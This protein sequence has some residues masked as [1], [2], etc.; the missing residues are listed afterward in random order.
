MHCVISRSP[1][2]RHHKATSVTS[3]G[4][5]P[6]SSDAEHRLKLMRPVSAAILKLKFFR[7]AQLS[8]TLAP[9]AAMSK[10]GEHWRPDF[11][12]ALGETFGDFV[13][14]PVSFEDASPHEC[15]EWFGQ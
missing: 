11:E 2:A 10:V 12:Q 13:S 7:G 5:L 9:E 8:V 15:C 14:P 4:P 6:K 3:N 1:L